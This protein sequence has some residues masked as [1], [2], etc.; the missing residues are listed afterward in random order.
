[1]IRCINMPCTRVGW[2][3]YYWHRYLTTG[4]DGALVLYLWYML[5]EHRDRS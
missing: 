4:N 1:M 2:I 5:L 3:N